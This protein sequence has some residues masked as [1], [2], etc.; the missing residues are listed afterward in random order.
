MKTAAAILFIIVNLPLF[1]R[2]VASDTLVR[3]SHHTADK[4]NVLFIAVDD[5][6][7]GL[8]CYGDSTAITPNIDKLAANGLIFNRAYCQQAVCNPSRASVMTGLRPN[9]T[10]VWDLETHFRK[11]LPDVVTLPQYFK[12]HGYHTQSVGKIYHDP[13][14][15]QDPPSWSVAETMAVT[16]TAGKYVLKR[17]LHRTGSWKA[18]ATE[19]AVVADDAYVDGKVSRSAIEILSEIRN[20]PFFLAVGFRRPHLPFSAPEKYW[21]MYDRETIPMPVHG[22][23]PTDVPVIALHDWVELRGYTDI[24]ETGGLSDDKIRE[25]IHGYYASTTYVDAQIGK[26]LEALDGLGLRD[27]TIVVLWSD[28]GFHLGEHGLWCKT[29]NFEIDTRVPLIISFPRVTKRGLRTDALVEL[30]DLYPTLADLA[31]LPIPNGVEGTSLK[32]LFDHPDDPLK[33]AAFSQFLRP[34]GR[35]GKVGVMGYSVRT[36]NFRYTEWLNLQSGSIEA[37]ELYDHPIDPLETKNLSG[38]AEYAHEIRTLR[39]TLNAI[40]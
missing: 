2:G 6:R 31:G 21:K 3:E 27:K 25:L 10:R 19:N 35:D 16:K 12:R 18:S 32:P 24:P 1:G 22:E 11:V 9:T 14:W 17:N 34:S 13:A 5:L 8:G 39:R 38:S 29:T 23:P 26:V 15:A 4:P 20:K 36:D 33:H 40:R 37:V 7:C 28:H 30:I